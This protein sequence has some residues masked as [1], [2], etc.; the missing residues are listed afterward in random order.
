M[1]LDDNISYHA[2]VT[3][4]KAPASGGQNQMNFGVG[5]A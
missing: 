3:E 1:E 5:K 2:L 4:E